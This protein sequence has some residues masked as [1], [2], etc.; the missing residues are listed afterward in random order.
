M[1]S[2]LSAI[3]SSLLL[4]GLILLLLALWLSRTARLPL[5]LRELLCRVALVGALGTVLL[6]SGIGA[7]RLPI[8]ASP[9]PAPGE[10]LRL[11]TPQLDFG[12]ASGFSDIA[13]R[14]SRRDQQPGAGDP[15][16]ALL[17]T[18]A[19][20]ASRV[21]AAELARPGLGV[22]L[23]LLWAAGVCLF[24][25]RY[26]RQCLAVRR[27]LRRAEAIT[28]ESF[29]AAMTAE[30]Q[31]LAMRRPPL[32]LQLSGLR[33]PF[34]I[35]VLRPR[36]VLDL[37]QFE[38]LLPQQ[39]R[40]LLRH[41]LA[42]LRSGDPFW[43]GLARI[44]CIALWPILPLWWLRSRMSELAEL[45]CD[46]LAAAGGRARVALAR[47]L[48]DFAERPREALPGHSI[49][50][51]AR[52]SELRTR[53]H[54]LLT[55]ERPW[56]ALPRLLALVPALGV[57]LLVPVFESGDSQSREATERAPARGVVR[58]ADAAPWRGAELV[59][60]GRIL[61]AVDAVGSL[62]VVRVQSD[63]SGRFRAQLL[64]DREYSVW[65][66][67]GLVSPSGKSVEQVLAQAE[68]PPMGFTDTW[69]LLRSEMANE[70]RRVTAVEDGV[71]AGQ[72][73]QLRAE[74][75]E[76]A[77]RLLRVRGLEEWK[78]HAP[79]RVSLLHDSRTLRETELELDGDVVVVPPFAGAHAVL[80]VR[81]ARGVLL[82][83]QLLRP[84]GDGKP[85]DIA[86][87]RRFV[88]ET[89]AK[90]AEEPLAGAELRVGP[91]R[92]LWIPERSPLWRHV[93]NAGFA[94]LGRTGADG[95]AAALLPGAR[96]GGLPDTHVVHVHAPG[97]A[98]FEL[99]D[100]RL[101]PRVDSRTGESLYRL[102]LEAAA[103]V[104]GQ[105]LV[106]EG[107]PAAGLPLLVTAESSVSTGEHSSAIFRV[108]AR[109]VET[110]SDGRF[111][112]TGLH[113]ERP[114][115]L[116][117]L[118]TR[119]PEEAGELREQGLLLVHESRPRAGSDSLELR[120]D[121]LVL[122]EIEVQQ[123]SG[124]RVAQPVLH[125]VPHAE[126][127]FRPRVAAGLRVVG[128]RRGRIRTLL[129]RKRQG[130]LVVA[131]EKYAL[132]EVVPG[133]EPVL[134]LELELA[135]MCIADGSVFDRAG[136]PL[137]GARVWISGNESENASAQH[138][139][140]AS[141]NLRHAKVTSGEDGR[142]RLAFLPVP[143]HVQKLR[144]SIGRRWSDEQVLL[145]EDA[146]GLQFHVPDE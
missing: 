32:A 6:G 84:S 117:A 2:E 30:S 141:Y 129:P 89:H 22:L 27:L 52:P 65:A 88:F 103:L 48:L 107:V 116:W 118:A 142:F 70:R 11:H 12:G 99:S 59:F 120:L 133:E 24:A 13:A 100:Y 33:S 122:V 127:S 93:R 80:L 49:A 90:G 50:M 126:E 128:D 74:A 119:L 34:A 81:D 40:L 31:A 137:P 5:A 28:S 108:P 60:V 36:L 130:L 20:P 125:L 138:I 14:D 131:G 42:H 78:Q 73:L 44:L 3:L 43:L 39:Q 58:G 143:R 56:V 85:L 104:Q 121:A 35:G 145:Q 67:R 144:A 132:G 46:E 146:L 66:Q 76:R 110:D 8:E 16:T 61:S 79:F 64:R 47:L 29:L 18:H 63:E 101:Q 109:V 75:A 17:P 41:E 77:A 96:D 55:P 111:R 71:R 94:A 1:L 9:Q 134:R 57:G 112:V 98:V 97:R 45:R 140:L 86:A 23:S 21:P 135:P 106:S 25:L 115:R 62:D 82:G 139:A 53:V 68:V 38:S 51:A 72:V 95:R 69:E 124:A 37:E 4:H 113:P 15:S 91:S 83:A 26:L 7:W 10:G 102:P 92:Q 136:K 114:F 123:P 54:A 19:V 105:V 87:P